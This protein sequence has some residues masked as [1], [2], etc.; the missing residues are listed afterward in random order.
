MTMTMTAH[1]TA[2]GYD[3]VELD[4]DGVGGGLLGLSNVAGTADMETMSEAARLLV[5]ARTM[6]GGWRRAIALCKGETDDYVRR[7][8]RLRARDAPLCGPCAVPGGDG[9]DYCPHHP[10]NPL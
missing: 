2:S 3:L 7:V 8:D 5:V 9:V 10:V 6:P 1:R 4:A